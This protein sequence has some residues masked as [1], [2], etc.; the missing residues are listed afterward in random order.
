MLYIPYTEGE[1]RKMAA[2]REIG[3]LKQKLR[4]TDYRAIKFAEGMLSE[5]EYAEMKAQ[6]QAWRD[7]INEL[8]ADFGGGV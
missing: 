6:R 3:E 1:L 4:E 8:E 5:D 7:R 2:Q